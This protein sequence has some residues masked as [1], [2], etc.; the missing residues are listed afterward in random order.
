MISC[1]IGD[2]LRLIRWQSDKR[3]ITCGRLGL[4]S[5]TMHPQICN[6]KCADCVKVCKVF[7]DGELREEK[8]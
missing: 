3:K 7:C 1:C 2:L 8:R 4:H 5:Q 6:K